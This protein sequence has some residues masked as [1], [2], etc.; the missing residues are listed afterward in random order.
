M[1]FDGIPRPSQINPYSDP[2]NPYI[3]AHDAA[4]EAKRKPSVKK[5][6]DVMLATT[7]AVFVS[8]PIG[9]KLQEYVT[10]SPDAMGARIVGI[11]QQQM[12]GLKIQ[13]VDIDW[14]EI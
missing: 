12:G 2:L 13:H 11:R 1:S 7:L 3:G 5:I 6:P 14:G 9:L 10:T 8:Q 4:D